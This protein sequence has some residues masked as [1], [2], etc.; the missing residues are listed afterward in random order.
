M[1]SFAGEKFRKG[2]DK[3]EGVEEWGGVSEQS[4]RLFGFGE[5]VHCC[6]GLEWGIESAM[7]LLKSAVRAAVLVLSLF[8]PFITISF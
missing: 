5:G 1:V 4:A 8:L 3:G 7:P 6:W 2:K